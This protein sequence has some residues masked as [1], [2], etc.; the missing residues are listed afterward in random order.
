MTVARRA[1]VYPSVEIGAAALVNTAVARCRAGASVGEAV[2]LAR[3]RDA[4]VVTVGGARHVL[5]EDLARASALGLEDLEARALERPLPV[6]GPREAEVRIR[7]YLREGAPA[8]VVADPRGPIGAVTDADRWRRPITGVS[9]A[10]R[11]SRR[12][13]PATRTLLDT[14]GALA[15]AHGARAFLVGG[16]VRDAWGA[17]R[18]DARDLDVVVEGD[19]LALARALAETIGG[20]VVEHRRFLTASVRT[21]DHRV[22]IATSRAERYEA[23]GALPR[24]IPAGIAQ[25][26]GR[27]DFTVNAM[28]VEL[29]SGSFDLLDPL[30]GRVD[31]GRRRLRVLHPLS[32]VEDPTRVF[33]AAR[34][35]ARLGFAEDAWTARARALAL[36]RVP[37][38]ALSPQRVAAELMRVMSEDRAHIA[39]R[40][41]GGGGGLRLL[42]PRY[43]FTAAARRRVEALPA[44][45]GWARAR[46]LA[47]SGFEVAALALVADQRRDVALA[48]LRG[49]AL[50]GEPFTRLA[51]AVEEWRAL[52]GAVGGA[53]APSAA[54]RLIRNRSA[55][56]VAWLWLTGEP[57]LRAR[58]DGVLER[59][60]EVAASLSGEDVIALGV[61][62]GPAVGRVLDAVRDARLD[63][64]VTDGAGEVEYVRQWARELGWTPATTLGK[65][66]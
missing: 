17:G 62:R 38:P 2:R 47:V 28:A 59:S 52:A 37:Y 32:F 61:P 23:P 34:Y 44:T 54:A 36:E 7:R 65:E 15:R 26:L 8:V 10:S 48:A 20:S 63:G 56:E 53:R 40:R 13:P 5:R 33:R 45:L 35:A 12:L 57:G 66:G 50:T 16:L 58:L 30:S 24:V 46:G 29:G 11:L 49:L 43:R 25:D 22:D 27:R 4:G 51:R 9:L 41:L 55:T 21:G 31:F 1:H 39:L 14:L 42:D 64:T 19:G 60:R 6:V 18:L 3:R